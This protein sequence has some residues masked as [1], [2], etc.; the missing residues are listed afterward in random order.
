MKKESFAPIPNTIME[1]IDLLAGSKLCYG[2]LLQYQ[3]TGKTAYPSIST[4]AK[5]LGVGRRQ[6]M[7]YL[8]ELEEHNLLTVEKRPGMRNHYVL[9]SSPVNS[10]APVQ[11]NS[12]VNSSSPTSTFQF[13]TPVN[14]SSPS[15]KEKREKNNKITI[16]ACKALNDCDFLEF[17]K[18]YPKRNGKKIGKAKTANLFQ[19]LKAADKEQIFTAVKNYA[20]SGQMAKDP[21]RFIKDDYWRDW[22]EPA[23]TENTPATESKPIQEFGGIYAN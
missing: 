6:I 9:N 19:K 23:E 3:G 20:A 2:R 14:S 21:E 15:T 7:N 10:N 11:S 1:R 22:L 12:L 17:W 4:L 5:N 8:K 16:Y 13:T 18:L